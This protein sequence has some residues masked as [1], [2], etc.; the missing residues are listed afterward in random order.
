MKTTRSAGEYVGEWAKHPMTIEEIEEAQD[1]KRERI[2][3]HSSPRT[4]RHK[5]WRLRDNIDVA[6]DDLRERVHE[7]ATFYWDEVDG[8]PVMV[9]RLPTPE[10]LP[11]DHGAH[12]LAKV[13]NEVGVT[14]QRAA[15]SFSK[16]FTKLKEMPDDGKV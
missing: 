11:D 14:A 7:A 9:M 4:T 3:T 10:D 2:H 1:V 15:D 12:R 16:L 6:E 13:M 5:G 8:Q